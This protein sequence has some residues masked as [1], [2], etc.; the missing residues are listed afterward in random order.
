MAVLRRT[1]HPLHIPRVKIYPK[2]G[3]E[4]DGTLLL[5]PSM[6]TISGESFDITN[7]NSIHELAGVLLT[8]LQTR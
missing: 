6:V 7:R 1:E 8:M 3:R 2:V 5:V 4:N